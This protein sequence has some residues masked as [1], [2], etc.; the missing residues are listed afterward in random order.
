M[1]HDRVPHDYLKDFQSELDIYLKATALTKY[2]AEWQPSSCAAVGSCTLVS[3]IEELWRDLY[4]RGFV[5][6]GDFELAQAWLKDLIALGYKFP[7]VSTASTS[8]N[9]KYGGYKEGRTEL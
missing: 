1:I 8:V 7:A 3:R 6:L 9:K 2:L 5:E 4:E